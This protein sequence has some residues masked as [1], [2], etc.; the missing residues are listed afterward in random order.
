M[1]KDNAGLNDQMLDRSVVF[2]VYALCILLERNQKYGASWCE[3]HL[4]Q[5]PFGPRGTLGHLETKFMRI[6]NMVYKRDPKKEDYKELRDSYIDN[7]NYSA[8]SNHLLDHQIGERRIE[9]L[10]LEVSRHPDLKTALLGIGG[11]VGRLTALLDEERIKPG[12][13]DA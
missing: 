12:L 6:Y 2:Y 5:P 9:E 7:A 10:L 1:V 3:S 4:T 11:V 13:A 8:L